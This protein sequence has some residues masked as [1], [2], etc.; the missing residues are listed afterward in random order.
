MVVNSVIVSPSTATVQ[1]GQTR[2]FS[3]TVSGTGNPPQTVTWTVTGGG[4]GTTI[5][6]TGLLRIAA[7][8]S[9]NSLTVRATSTS[10]NRRNGTATVTV[11]AASS[12]NQNPLAGTTWE[13]V[14]RNDNDRRYR[15]VYTQ[16]NVT[17]TIFNRDGS[18]F[19]PAITGT[20]TLQG[21]NLTKNFDGH[22]DRYVFEQSRIVSSA[23]RSM[24]YTRR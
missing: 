11:T 6:N 9:A 1:R 22:I 8:D 10:D 3:A 20:Y 2:Q 14:D 16:N 15:L 4:S 18:V 23:N 19:S 13:F 12:A 24:I 5:S 17:F 21:T 7:N